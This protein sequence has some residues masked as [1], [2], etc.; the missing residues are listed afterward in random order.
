MAADH[1]VSPYET[2]AA[3]RLITGRPPSF[4]HVEDLG[5]MMRWMSASTDADDGVSV[6]K[7]TAITTGRYVAKY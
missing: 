6:I 3:V 7:V 5:T 4:I 1:G 2:V